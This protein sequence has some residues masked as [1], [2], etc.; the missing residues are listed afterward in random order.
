MTPPL[1]VLLAP[2]KFKGCL[3]AID[4]CKELR[5]GLLASAFPVEVVLRPMADGGEGTLDAAL[6]AGFEALPVAA[7]DPLGRP[8]TARI[9]VRGSTALIEL[10]EICG[11]A[12]LTGD[13]K[14]PMRAT[15]YGVGMAMTAAV[16]WGHRRLVVGIGGSAS[17]DGG[18]GAATALG[19]RILD[20]NGQPVRPG[21]A[22]LDDVAS[23]DLG[24]MSAL[25][26][27]I[28]LTV[29]TDVSSPLHGQFGAARVFAAQKG[30]SPDQVRDLDAGLRNWSARL[31]ATTGIDVSA[32]SG[33]GAAG[34]F[35]APFLATGSA[36]IASG[37][38]LVLDLT[39]TRPAI[40]A[41]TVVVT[42]EGRW[43][44]QTAAG[45]APHA[46]LDAAR[47]ADT[48]VIAV[49][50]GFAADADLTG[51]LASYSLTELARP[52]RD[53]VRDVRALLREIGSRIARQ[54]LLR[55]FPGSGQA[56]TN[57]VKS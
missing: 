29:A 7:A 56:A 33:G 57:S 30:A 42:G 6:L 34:G 43:D 17:T 35:A 18:I 13:T 9:G 24:P 41:A 51:V 48:P 54:P 37:A 55:S 25:L 31:L 14:D 22:G 45:K 36:R 26:D 52:D 21:G 16:E 4:V 5:T 47:K 46:V 38:Q 1:T 44:T 3:A 15:T 11:L 23:I 39:D 2:D 20:H 53:P 49:A 12:L 8:R 19:A 28:S 32:L 27:G 50:G 10:A 40:A